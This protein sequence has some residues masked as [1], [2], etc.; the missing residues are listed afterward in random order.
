MRR[1]VKKKHESV[2]NK[3][4]YWQMLERPDTL[5][6]RRGCGVE[7]VEVRNSVDLPLENA[8]IDRLSNG[9]PNSTTQGP[10]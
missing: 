6:E 4:I 10:K 2:I 1:L 9:D 5:S 7:P 3:G 8:S